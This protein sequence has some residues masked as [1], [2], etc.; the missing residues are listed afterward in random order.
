MRCTGSGKET[1][2]PA[3]ALFGKGPGKKYFF[4]FC[5][6]GGIISAESGW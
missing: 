3:K 4:E 1:P 6:F 2:K 5:V